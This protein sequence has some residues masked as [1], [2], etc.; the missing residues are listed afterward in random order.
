MGA[1][2]GFALRCFKAVTPQI[3]APASSHS[4]LSSGT[5]SALAPFLRKLGVGKALVQE[6]V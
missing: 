1:W 2:G 4:L 5:L 3:L 6:D